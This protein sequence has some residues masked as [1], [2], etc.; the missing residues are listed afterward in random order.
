MSQ[1]LHELK[2]AKFHGGARRGDFGGWGARALAAGDVVL[3]RATLV[4]AFQVFARSFRELLVF[5]EVPLHRGVPQR[6]GLGAR[7]ATATAA[8]SPT[9][10]ATATASREAPPAA[11]TAPP[12]VPSASMVA[13]M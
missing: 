4:H 12:L 2:S 1:S 13:F 7:P 9:E 6:S 10:I 8:P 11:P 5:V 3:A